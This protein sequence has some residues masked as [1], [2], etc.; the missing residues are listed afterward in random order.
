M[1]RIEF[2]FILATLAL[3]RAAVAQDTNDLKTALGQFESRTGVV[4]VKGIS[5]MGFIPLGTIQI[6][7]RCKETTDNTT[8]QKVFGLAVG[9]SDNGQSAEVRVLVDEDELSALINAVN[10]LKQMDSTVT[11]LEGFEGTFSTK[12]GFRVI[13]HSDRKEGTVR[14]YLQFYDYPRVEVTPTQIGQFYNLL[15]QSRTTLVN[16][17]AGK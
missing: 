4:L 16:L 2:L 13:A 9:V 5:Q 8:G 12:A 10:D 6:S 11:A 15:Q 7:V 17:K 14:F 1:K 3:A